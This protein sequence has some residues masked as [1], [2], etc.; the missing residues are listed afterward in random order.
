MRVEP[1][2][3]KKVAAAGV[4]LVAV[5]VAVSVAKAIAIAIAIAV[6][7][8]AVVVVVVVIVVKGY[9]FGRIFWRRNILIVPP[10]PIAHLPP[11]YIQY[12]CELK[13]WEIS[14]PESFKS[15]DQCYVNISVSLSSDSSD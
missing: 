13:I 3:L 15:D 12:I 7:V 9:V 6:A 4:V 2:Y 14:G 5:P 10:G 8:A 1:L 11:K